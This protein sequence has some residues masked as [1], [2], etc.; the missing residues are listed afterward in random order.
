MLDAVRPALIIARREVRDQFRDWRII[1]PIIGLTLVFPFIMNWTAQQMLGFT[2]EYGA[3]IVADRLVPFLLMVVGF[4][5]I[6]VSLVIALESFVGEKERGS[7]EPLLNTPLKDWQLYLGK[8]LSST[9]PP[10]VSSYLGMIVYLAGL[11]IRRITIPE[12]GMLVQ[13]VVLTTVQAVMMVAGAVAVSLQATSVRSA[14]LLSSFII[15]PTAFLIQWE[16]LVMFWGNQNLLW[17]VIVAV[18]ILTFL[19]VRVGVAHFQREELL[20]RDIDVLKLPWI[21]GVF[22]RNFTGH[23]RS[24][25]D[26]YRQV[27]LRSLPRLTLPVLLS[28]GLALAGIWAGINL[29]DRFIVPTSSST[30]E[31]FR[32]SLMQL[33]GAD[34]INQW[35]LARMIFFQNIR[36]L[37]IGMLLGVC[38]FGVLGVLPLF[39]TM[40]LA[41]ALGRAMVIKGLSLGTILSSLLPHG[42]LEIP[43]VILATAA[44]LQLGAVLLTPTPG[45][46]IGEAWVAALA[47][48]SRVMVGIVIPLLILA[49]LV[50]ALLTPHIALFFLQ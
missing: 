15:I 43:A 17:W 36:A 33:F 4:F 38:S 31:K 30:P 8:L 41:G 37:L 19:L 50:E 22:R 35:S 47:E 49:A 10:L 11:M 44:V 45:Q 29:V 9:V 21:W 34:S 14:N 6:S 46:T 1:F 24:V 42:V 23:A 18:V 20:G 40:G 26:W 39:T 5:P 3:T 2:R 27:L 7:I 25:G 28:A 16:A 12:G 32:E 48:W 13:I